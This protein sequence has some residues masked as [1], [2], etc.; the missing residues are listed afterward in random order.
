MAVFELARGLP[1]YPQ[2]LCPLQYSGSIHDWSVLAI[3]AVSG[4]RLPQTILESL[5]RQLLFDLGMGS[6]YSG[7][8]L[9]CSLT[10]CSCRNGEQK[11]SDLSLR[12][13]SR[14][15]YV[16]LLP[17]PMVLQ[18]FTPFSRPSMLSIHSSPYGQSVHFPLTLITG[19]CCRSIGG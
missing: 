16:E 4:R 5:L 10:S 19:P 1:Y 7:W 13:L 8:R 9:Y 15:Y 11:G 3:R 14:L 17:I 12:L 18:S 6:Q 2:N